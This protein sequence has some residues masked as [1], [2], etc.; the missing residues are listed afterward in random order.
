MQ[1]ALPDLRFVFVSVIARRVIWVTTLQH[2][3]E[4]S[5]FSHFPCNN[6]GFAS[7]R[8]RRSNAMRANAGRAAAPGGTPGSA[9]P[10]VIKTNNQ[11][12]KLGPGMPVSPTQLTCCATTLTCA[13]TA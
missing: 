1:F 12:I 13:A 4:G 7:N 6:G 5:D 3:G 11:H 9:E 2:I 10:I 8:F